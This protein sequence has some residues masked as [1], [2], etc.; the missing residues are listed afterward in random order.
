MLY[1]YTNDIPDSII[2]IHVLIKEVRG[3]SRTLYDMW[4]KNNLDIQ[5]HVCPVD[6]G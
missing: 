6:Q 5:E 2:G 1:N 4:I 3:D